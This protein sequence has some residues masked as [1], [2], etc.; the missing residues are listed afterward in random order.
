MSDTPSPRDIESAWTGCPTWLVNN[1][2]RLIAE[3]VTDAQEEIFWLYTRKQADSSTSNSTG[4]GFINDKT[5]VLHL[6]LEISD[7]LTNHD[8]HQHDY[9]IKSTR[10]KHASSLKPKASVV[11][12]TVVQLELYQ[13]LDALRHRKGDTGSVLWRV[14]SHF[15]QYLISTG[16]FPQLATTSL[17]CPQ[18]RHRLTLLELGS[19]TGGLGIL[20]SSQFKHWTFTD[21]QI[22]LNLISKNLKHNGITNS[23]L[24][25]DD[26]VLTK[27]SS[28]TLKSLT[29]KQQQ[30]IKSLTKSSSNLK[31]LTN[32]SIEELDWQVESNIYI[33]QQGQSEFRR[34]MSSES[35]PPPDIILAVDCL[36]NP[37]LSPCLAH[38][39][40]NKAGKDTVV[41]V[42]SELRDS[43]PL[44]SFLNTWLQIRSTTTTTT[45][46]N[47][48]EWNVVRV[49]FSNEWSSGIG[50]HQCVVWV[51]WRR[52]TDVE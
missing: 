20:L 45:N 38:T 48:M 52:N 43:E 16:R 24:L 7:P 4:L 19:G 25:R 51:G 32:T 12:D 13:D 36:Y 29:S 35:S 22:N 1:P 50:S 11:A 28:S 42:I 37:H 9:N 2:T 6:T 21:Q 27:T 40:D 39:I 23:P 14:S 44:E 31:Q 17:I 15:A 10:R 26:K 18:D 3:P 49:E 8:Q 47:E 30:N 46:T 34:S 41:I 33:K 5:D